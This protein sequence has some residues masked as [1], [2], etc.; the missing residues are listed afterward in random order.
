VRVVSNEC[1]GIG[2]D[3]ATRFRHLANDPVDTYPVALRGRIDALD[4]RL[5]PTVNEG[6]GAAARGSRSARGALLEAFEQIDSR[7]AHADYLVGDVLTEA[8]IRLW[9]TLVRYDVGPNATR[10]VNP[11]LHV[12]PHLWR[13]ARRL[14]RIPAFRD[15]TDFDAF[16]APG[17]ERPDWSG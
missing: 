12:Y 2:I 11:G 10:A 17:A 15:T 9:V 8:D 16:T 7:L 14:Y 4:R 13:Y 6:V 5:R 1:T 3:L